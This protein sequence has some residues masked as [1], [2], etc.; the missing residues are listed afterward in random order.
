ML[1][2][3][4]LA[5]STDIY[6]IDFLKII[7]DCNHDSDEL[8][9]GIS[10]HYPKHDC[11]GR[12][13]KSY[14]KIP[15]KSSYSSQI[16][17]KSKGD[18]KLQLEGNFYKFL[19]GHN[20]TGTTNLKG[21]V[22]DTLEKLKEYYPSS[23]YPTTK[24]L[25][26]IEL[27]FFTIQ[28]IDINKAIILDDSNTA[29]KYLDALKN[30]ATYPKRINKHIESNGIY[31]NMNSKRSV[32]KYYYKG[33][34]IKENSE[35]QNNLTDDL[36]ALADIMIRCEVKLKWDYLKENKLL[37]GFNWFEDINKPKAI[38]NK[39]HEKLIIPD[40][41][42]RSSLPKNLQR[43]L[44]CV[45]VGNQYD[46]YGLSTIKKYETALKNYAVIQ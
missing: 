17:I 4:Q 41:T 32:I 23:F 9:T 34:E 6:G 38:I 26:D 14:H 2:K 31:F 19:N 22:L 10:I 40:V 27:G 5:V 44:A 37:N 25:N 20:I 15:I 46:T 7:I 42:N 45:E 8:N 29:L 39:I 12:S 18:S 24:Q 16:T 36:I 21:L 13:F 1:D 28:R 11:C 43:Y 33:R 30:Y 3:P 35:Y